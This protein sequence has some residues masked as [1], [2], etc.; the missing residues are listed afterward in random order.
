MV[1]LIG[2]SVLSTD[3]ANN[4]SLAL[5]GVS[6]CLGFGSMGRLGGGRTTGGLVGVAEKGSA[7]VSLGAGAEEDEVKEEERDMLINPEDDEAED[8]EAE[9]EE[10]DEE[11]AILG[12][13]GASETMRGR[14]EVS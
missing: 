12:A 13:D 11:R 2:S 7:V 1:G 3:S 14:L 6:G 5:A 10:K 9:E 8:E 4:S